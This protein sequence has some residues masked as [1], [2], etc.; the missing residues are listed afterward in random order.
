M[1][2]DQ[3]D[4]DHIDHGTIVAR[5]TRKH[6]VPQRLDASTWVRQRT[7]IGDAGALAAADAARHVGVGLRSKSCANFDSYQRGMLTSITGSK[8]VQQWLRF[9]LHARPISAYLGIPSHD[10]HAAILHH[11]T[12]ALPHSQTLH[13]SSLNTTLAT[14]TP[15][16]TQPPDLSP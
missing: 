5:S 16:P 11:L 8:P 1:N 13:Q 7:A 12:R 4:S 6:L 2:A 15:I 10:L 14:H 3:S 9:Q